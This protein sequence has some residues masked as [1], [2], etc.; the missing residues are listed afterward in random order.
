MIIY[1]EI[2]VSVRFID[3][4]CGIIACNMQERGGTLGNKG[5]DQQNQ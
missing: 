1:L 4:S 2:N 5:T 3:S